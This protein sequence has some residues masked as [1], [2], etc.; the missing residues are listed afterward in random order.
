VSRRDDLALRPPDPTRSY[1]SFPCRLLRAGAVLYRAHARGPWWFCSQGDCRFDLPAPDGTCYLATDA[2]AAVREKVGPALAA[3]G[4]VPASV[5]AG[6]LVSRLSVPEPMQLANPATP[7][8]ANRFG[9]TREID[10]APYPLAQE[11]ARAWRRAGF[12]GVRYGTRFT[13]AARPTGVALFGPAGERPWPLDP[14][15]ELATDIARR[16]GLRLVT[17]PTAAALTIITPWEYVAS[18]REGRWPD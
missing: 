8:A 16:T 18:V 4:L 14:T 1:H 12:H 6:V 7:T 9:M 2:G 13:P 15:P 5:L 3:T 17:P 11:W 10:T